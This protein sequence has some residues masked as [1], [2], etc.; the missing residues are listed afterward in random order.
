MQSVFIGEIIRQKRL[1]LGL[2]QEEVCDGICEPATLSRIENGR[3]TPSRSRL[4]A[5]LQR[6]DLPD[7]RYYALVSKNE[8]EIEA[9]K[10]EITAC[11]VFERVNEGFEKL[12]QLEAMLEP[13]DDLGRQFVLRCRALLGR[14]DGRFSPDQELEML[15]QAI[16]L[17]VPKFDLDEIADGL[18]T[19]D[20]VK[21]INQ[22]A[23]TYSSMNNNKKAADICYQ[24]L[25]YIRKHYHEVLTS[26]GML[27][28][29][30]CNYAR[31][32][33]LCGRYEES[34]D[35]AEQ[36]RQACIKYGHYHVIP[37]CLALY[38]ECCHFMGKDKESIKAYIKSYVLM[39]ALGD[40]HNIG[41][42]RAEL[43]KYH[44]IDVESLL[45]F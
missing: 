21:I 24:L 27:P 9:L 39:D 13:D 42:V 15:M 3:Q 12:A 41:I 10:K 44:D 23:S 22:I 29:V 30:L 5:L 32:L 7:D 35:Y 26:N 40:Q 4:N 19:F 17:T 38:A 34:V 25:R 36:G 31:A 6:L 8:A 45:G 1:A 2:S 37:S 11:N 16:K 33:D 14:L 20:E 28:M 18:Y 43:K